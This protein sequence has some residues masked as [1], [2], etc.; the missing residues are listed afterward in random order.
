MAL[1]EKELSAIEDQLSNEKLLITKF[2]A[3]SQMCSDS[4]I[5]QKCNSIASRHQE[6]Y[7]RLLNFLS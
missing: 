1:T 2:K 5:K 7:D 4:D 6:H 3:Y